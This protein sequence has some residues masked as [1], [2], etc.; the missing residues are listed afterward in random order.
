MGG[1]D[2]LIIDHIVFFLLAVVLP[3]FS[4]KR[5]EIK[6]EDEWNTKIKTTFYFTNSAILWLGAISILALW[7]FCDRSFWMLGFQSP[8]LNSFTLFISGLFV[9]LYAYHLYR[10]LITTEGIKKS[11]LKWKGK[12]N[13]MP[14]NFREF[15]SYCFLSFTAG[16]TEE[17]IFR[18]Y[19]INYILAFGD[20]NGYLEVC[21][22]M[23]IPSLIFGVIHIYQ[24]FEAVQ[25]IVIGGLIF[26]A[27]YY[28]SQSLVLVIIFHILVDVI[29]GY[30]LMTA[31]NQESREGEA[32]S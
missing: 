5:G 4:L 13:F 7:Y 28:Y 18:G 27:I 20:S 32:G 29:T 11:L 22:A 31:L 10:D 6:L 24:G 12:S 25:K 9:L 16:V 23:V 14:V 8:L 19:L 15:Y 26:G 3:G 30:F 2:N 21:L 17:I 1:Y